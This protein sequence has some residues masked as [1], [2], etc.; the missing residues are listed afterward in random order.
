MKTINLNQN[1]LLHEAPL[2]YCSTDLQ[3]VQLYDAEWMECNLPTDVRMP[4][5]QYGKIKDPTLSDYCLDSE[6]VANRSWWFLK[7]LI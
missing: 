7:N 2:N 6:W 4:L 3:K 5:I 1:W